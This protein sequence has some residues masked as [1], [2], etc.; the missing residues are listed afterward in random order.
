[1]LNVLLGTDAKVKERTIKGSRE[2]NAGK[3]NQAE[4]VR[5]FEK[6]F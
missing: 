6:M 3:E 1:M 4:I 5:N 2:L